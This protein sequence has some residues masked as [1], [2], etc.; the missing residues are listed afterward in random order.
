MLYGLDKELA[1]KA[2]AKYDVGMEQE[3]PNPNPNP[4]PNRNPS[5]SPSPSPNP[6]PNSNPSPNPKQV[7]AALPTAPPRAAVPP[8]EDISA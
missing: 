6:N 2:A 5:P 7:G 3:G 8:I 4:H 1:E